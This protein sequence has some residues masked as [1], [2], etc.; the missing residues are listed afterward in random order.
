MIDVLLL[1]VVL[2]DEP[3]EAQEVRRDMLSLE[4]VMAELG[5]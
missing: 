2:D 1:P 3:E 5:I 4:E